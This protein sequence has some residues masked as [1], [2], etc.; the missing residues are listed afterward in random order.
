MGSRDTP[1]PAARLNALAVAQQ[2]VGT[3]VDGKYRLTSV[4]AVGGMGVV[5]EAEHLFLARPVALKVLHP[6]YEDAHDAAKRFLREASLLGSIGHRAIVE[7]LDGGF[8][9]GTTP[10]LVME[11]LCGENLAQRIHRRKALRL[12]QAVTVLREVLKGLAAAHAKGIVH[13]DLKPENVFLIDRRIEAGKIKIL[14]FG[15]AR[16]WGVQAT[17]AYLGHSTSEE[18]GVR[19][20]GT[21][22]YMAPEQ[23][24]GG[25]VGPHTDMY[26]A[27]VVTY[28]SLTGA[29]PFGTAA[30]GRARVFARILR[31]EAPPAFGLR[32]EI[33]AALAVLLERLLA[34]SPHDRPAAATDVLRAV[35]EMQLLPMT[36]VSAMRVAKPKG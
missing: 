21:P 6:R 18:S 28:E 22:E 25:E 12:V 9:D 7:I 30:A 11:R 17:L 32:E 4:L 27:G 20:Y 3:T 8:V 13:C 31:E 33:P 14:D 29:P 2:R 10:Y 16:M 35:D 26:G 36:S 5:Y 1:A 34:K 19:Q 23:I 15:V 24:T